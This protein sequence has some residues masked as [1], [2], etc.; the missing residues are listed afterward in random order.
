MYWKFDSPGGRE[1]TVF[2]D[3]AD[4]NRE[5]MERDDRSSHDE[6]GNITPAPPMAS[7]RAVPIRPMSILAAIRG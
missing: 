3:V 6:T 2:S 5:T 1:Q 4:G 7:T